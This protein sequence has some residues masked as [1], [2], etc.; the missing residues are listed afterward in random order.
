MR[1]TTFLAEGTQ[2]SKGLGAW[3]GLLVCSG[4]LT[5]A[6]EWL[7][8]EKRG[9]PRDPGGGD[10][11]QIPSRGLEGA[12]PVDGAIKWVQ[13]AVTTFWAVQVRGSSPGTPPLPLQANRPFLPSWACAQ[14]RGS[15]PRPEAERARPPAPPA[16]Q[17]PLR[18]CRACRACCPRVHVC[19]CVRL[20][21]DQGLGASKGAS[22]PGCVDVAPASA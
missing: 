5:P 15:E 2:G 11:P 7:R 1:G 14:V 10:G 21:Q 6:A 3:S 19:L 13:K 17:P 22:V 12:G 18:V 8:F 4:M 20:H 9:G 16:A